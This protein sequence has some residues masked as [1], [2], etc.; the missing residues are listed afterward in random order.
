MG[1]WAILTQLTSKQGRD[2]PAEF[3]LEKLEVS[4]NLSWHC[5]H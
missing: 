3:W 5:H 4:L 2:A 1:S